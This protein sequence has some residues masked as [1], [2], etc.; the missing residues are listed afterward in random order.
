MI[1]SMSNSESVWVHGPMCDRV[2]MGQVALSAS[3]CT[4]LLLLTLWRLL[5]IRWVCDRV[6][7]AVTVCGRVM[8]LS[9]L[10]CAR[11]LGA[12]HVFD[13]E[14]TVHET[15]IPIPLT[16]SPY[17]S[18]D[19]A[20]RF[21]NFRIAF[22]DDET[23]NCRLGVR[24]LGRLGIPAKNIVILSDGTLA[25]AVNTVWIRGEESAAWTSWRVVVGRS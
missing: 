1:V 15:T 13:S 8:F 20:A 11:A 24:M 12:G 17:S 22:V 25:A 23:A 10:R 7:I 2:G 9:V 6:D 16:T 14:T 21:S 19:W 18:T 5:L 4:V 3:R